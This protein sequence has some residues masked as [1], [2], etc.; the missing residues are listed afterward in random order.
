MFD[1]ALPLATQNSQIYEISRK[2]I[3]RNVYPNKRRQPTATPGIPDL[4]ES[5]LKPLPTTPKEI[6]TP[7]DGEMVEGGLVLI[8]AP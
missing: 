6:E 5:E 8:V 3:D 7:S 4:E 2:G 1:S